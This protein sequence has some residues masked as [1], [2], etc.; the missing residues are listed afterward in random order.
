MDI[1][2]IDDPLNYKWGVFYNNKS[3]VRIIVPKRARALGWTLNFSCWQSYFFVAM[4]LGIVVAAIV[5]S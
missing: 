4:L 3:D 2:P 5:M 1:D